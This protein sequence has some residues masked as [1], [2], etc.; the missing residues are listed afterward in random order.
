MTQNH[1][2]IRVLGVLLAPLAFSSLI[3]TCTVSY[4]RTTEVRA[5]AA[6][7][8]GSYGDE[9]AARSAVLSAWSGRGPESRISVPARLPSPSP[10]ALP[11]PR[12]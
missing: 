1:S 4:V 5:P 9:V 8:H 2:G 7:D 12:R 3:L 6:E 11:L 10:L